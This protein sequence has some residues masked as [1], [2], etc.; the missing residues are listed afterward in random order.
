MPELSQ[1][2]LRHSMQS[3]AFFAF[4]RVNRRY[5]IHPA[6][7]LPADSRASSGNFARIAPARDLPVPEIDRID[8]SGD[9]ITIT[10]RNAQTIRWYSD[11]GLVGTGAAF[12]VPANFGGSFVRATVSHPDYGVLKTQPFGIRENALPA[13]TLQSVARNFPPTL[14]LPNGSSLAMIERDLPMGTAITTNTAATRPASIAWNLNNLDYDPAIREPQT[15]TVPGTV[16]LPAGVAQSGVSLAVSVQVTIEARIGFRNYDMQTD[17]NLAAF[18]GTGSAQQSTHLLLGSNSGSR[19]VNMA[20]NPRTITITGRSGTSQGVDIHLDRL[21]TQPGHFYQFE[22]TGRVT[23]GAGPHTMFINAVNEAGGN[24]GNSLATASVA[25]NTAFTISHTASHEEIAHQLTL[26]QGARRYRFGG[27]SAQTLVVTGITV[28]EIPPQSGLIYCMQI[29]PGAAA[30][31]NLTGAGG[32]TGA[33]RGSDVLV[34]NGA[35]AMQVTANS[36]TSRSVTV[37]GRGGTGQGVRIQPANFAGIAAAQNYRIEIEG[38]FTSAVPSSARLRFENTPARVIGTAPVSANGNFTLDIIM[39]GAQILSDASGGSLTSAQW[40]IG[41]DGSLTPDMVITEVRVTATDVVIP[42]P[43]AVTFNPQSGTLPPG[44]PTSAE[45]NANGR[46]PAMPPPPTREN[47]VFNGWFSSASGGERISLDTVFEANATIHAQWSQ[48][49]TV[50]FNPHGGT[51]NPTSAQTGAGG[52]LTLTE[53][54]TPARAGWTFLGWFT[55]A[56]GGESVALDRVYTADTTVHAQWSEIP[57]LVTF[58]ANSGTLPSGTVNPATVAENG[59]LPSLPLPTR[60]GHAFNGWFTAATEGEPVTSDTV[61]AEDAAIFAQ[62][63]QIRTITFNPRGGELPEDVPATALTGV[64]GRLTLTELP[65]PTRAGHD[66]TGWFTAATGGDEVTLA[67]QYTAN[68]TIN[69]QWSALPVITCPDCD[70]PLDDCVCV[71]LCEH[72]EQPVD[73]CTCVLCEHCDELVC[74]CEPCEHCDKYPCECEKCE[75]CN[76]FPCVCAI[77]IPTTF[78]RRVFTAICT[79]CGELKQWHEMTYTVQ[80]LESG[81]PIITRRLTAKRDMAG[82][83]SGTCST[84]VWTVS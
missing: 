42:D 69:A 44:T 40:S 33:A 22:F 2:G 79:D 73:A 7:I 16:R 28:T 57:I 36:G 47:F 75:S 55:A 83:V 3:G 41:N 9:T 27:A 59:R 21:L 18:A 77:P 26:A 1:S 25:A 71:E 58:N 45:V 74:V 8:V 81:R 56:T 50:T 4:S 68:A 72:C 30:F 70:E 43:I 67:T 64:N 31:N 19:A 76:E 12:T 63:S 62:W 65:V 34:R 51:A 66:F 48:I 32:S 23:T 52:R 35:A 14:T 84:K 78:V 17:P 10:A 61:F 29:T 37:I 5:A 38:R 24:I 11:S 13:E 39:S 20:A 46:L 15:F 53:L 49:R 6:P 82:R 54:P 60:S 80:C